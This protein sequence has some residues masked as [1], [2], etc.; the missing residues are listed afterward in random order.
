MVW[1]GLAFSE[2][3]PGISKGV[4]AHIQR[5]VQQGCDAENLFGVK[6]LSAKGIKLHSASIQAP[7]DE[8]TPSAK[9]SIR[10]QWTPH[11]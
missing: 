6:R 11:P 1:P 5:E 3:N 7:A 8:S 10:N 2:N 4:Q 9:C